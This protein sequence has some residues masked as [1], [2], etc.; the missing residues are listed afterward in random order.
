[1]LILHPS[2]IFLFSLQVLWF[3]SMWTTLHQSTSQN[4]KPWW[5]LMPPKPSRVHWSLGI[6]FIFIKQGHNYI[7]QVFFFLLIQLKIW[8]KEKLWSTCTAFFPLLAISIRYC[9]LTLW[10]LKGSYSCAL[11]FWSLRPYSFIFLKIS[12][13]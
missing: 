11:K 6:V 4:L 3:Q 13:D 10:F 9:V 5:V 12:S 8:K 2:I 7:I 1:M